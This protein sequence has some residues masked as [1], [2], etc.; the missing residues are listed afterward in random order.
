MDKV[1]SNQVAD[2]H[3]LSSCA[4]MGLVTVICVDASGGLMSKPM[5][6]SRIRIGERDISN[7]MTSEINEV[8]LDKLKQG[9]SVSVLA[10]EFI[11]S[12]VSNSL[13]SWAENTWGVNRESFGENLTILQSIANKCSGKGKWSFGTSTRWS[14]LASSGGLKRSFFEETRSALTDLKNER[15]KIKLVSGHDIVAVKALA[16]ELGIEVPAEDGFILQGKE[17]Q[18]LNGPARSKKL[19]EALVMGGFL[20]DH[21]V[22]MIRCLQ[23]EGDVVAFFGG[24]TLND[25]A[26]REAA[27]IVI[28][29][30]SQN[31]KSDM[32]SSNVSIE[33]FSAITTIVRA[34]RCQYHNIQKFIQFQLTTNLSGLF[35]TLITTMCTGQSPLT[36]IQLIWV[37]SIVCILGGLM[38]LMN[39]DIRED[40][41]ANQPNNRK[42]SLI[43]QEIWK[44]IAIDVLLRASVSMIFL[45]GGQVTDS[46]KQVRKTMIF[47]I[48][49]LCQV[50]KQ[51]NFLGLAM[52]KGVFKMVPLSYCFLV[53][54]GVCLVMQVLVIQFANS[55]ADCM[56]LNATQWVICFL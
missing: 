1:V 32:E 54:L 30:K 34:G 45:F 43:T 16:C 4:T 37:N 17:I 7:D 33:C 46:T 20:P 40:Q 48:F 53:A 29:A 3:D 5:E 50:F 28:D 12:P 2:L 44:D 41:H 9:A 18:D 6:V 11:L 22:L 25:P 35:I 39:L 24:L 51:L 13:I 8:V 21:K 38:M 42:Q 19:D 52:K 14:N 55:L 15:I 47:N 56:S 26:V 23:D 27:D 49:M 31:L 36:A 10:P